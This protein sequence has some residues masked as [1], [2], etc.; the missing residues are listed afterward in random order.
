MQL[1]SLQKPPVTMGYAICQYDYEENTENT[2][3]W[4]SQVPPFGFM[5]PDVGFDLWHGHFGLCLR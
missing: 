1:T 4:F 2:E 5:D 3:I